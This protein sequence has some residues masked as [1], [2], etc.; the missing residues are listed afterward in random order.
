MGM[1]WPKHRIGGSYLD[2]MTASLLSP[3]EVTDISV[4]ITRT[5][6]SLL[7]GCADQC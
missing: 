5:Q 3:P 6:M 4:T 2:K 1:F 7:E